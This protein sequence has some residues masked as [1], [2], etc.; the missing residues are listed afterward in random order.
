MGSM[1]ENEIKKDNI[2]ESQ[3]PEKDIA[4]EYNTIFDENVDPDITPINREYIKH[5]FGDDLTLR[6]DEVRM[7]RSSYVQEHNEITAYFKN[8]R[9]INLKNL[10]MTG[11]I[12]LALAFLTK[13]FGKILS[14]SANMYFT[15]LISGFHWVLFVLTFLIPFVL[16]LSIIKKSKQIKKSEEHAFRSLEDRK[17]ECMLAGVYDAGR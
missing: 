5:I 10:I 11:V 14:F 15:A 17:K 12:F 1:N 6:T 16:V 2:E 8:E 7:T 9:T 13:A 4:A 3:A